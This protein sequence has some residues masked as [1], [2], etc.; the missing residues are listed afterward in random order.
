MVRL[1]RFFCLACLIAF[2][3]LAHAQAYPSKAIKM[4]V[5]FPAGGSTDL[6]ARALGQKLSEA[7]HA[8]VVVD[9]RPGA[10]GNIG[11]ESVA[12]AIP[13]GYTLLMAPAAFATNPAF[14]AK[15][16]WDPIKDFAAIS[17][18]ATVPIIVVVHPGLPVNNARELIAY[19]RSNPGK[20]NMASPGGATL[21]RVSGEMFRAAAGIDW[22]TVHYKGGPPA[23]NAM[24]SGEAQVMF[25]GI[26]DVFAQV[27]AGKLRPIAAGTLRRSAVVPELPTLNESVLPGYD[28]LMWQALL[29]PAGMPK[30]IVA[31][32]NAETVR[33]L[34]TP[35]MKARFLAFGTD[36]AGSTPAQATEFLREEVAKITK[37]VKDIGAKIE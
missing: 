24:L 14:F 1:R 36:A 26:S 4:V 30:E 15:L 32:L 31:K 7:L 16:S 33:I 25:A 28:V 12:R 23:M 34:A 22:V 5:P 21:A 17:L 20:L 6:P 18:V 10:S 29:A 2:S 37:V 11:I 13:D 9:N 35:E 8:P 19:A 3:H 27:K